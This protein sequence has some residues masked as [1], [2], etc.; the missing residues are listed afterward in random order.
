ML[1][2]KDIVS[3]ITLVLSNTYYYFRTINQN[4]GILQQVGDVAQW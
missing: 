3:I 1:V 2:Y 4:F